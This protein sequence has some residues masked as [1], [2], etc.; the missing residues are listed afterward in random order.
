VMLGSATRTKGTG[1]LLSTL[2]SSQATSRRPTGDGETASS[3]GGARV[4]RA[5]AHRGLVAAK[6]S[7]EEPRG[8]GGGL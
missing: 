7:G 2:R 4:S 5:A 6:A 3:G 8:C 1:G